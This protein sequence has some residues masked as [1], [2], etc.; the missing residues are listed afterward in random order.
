MKKMIL[1][2]MKIIMLLLSA[3]FSGI[4][5]CLS[6]AGLIYN[7]ESYG[8]EISFA[9]ALWIV[10]GVLMVSGAFTSLFR[11]SFLR[12]ISII[13]S[14]AGGCLCVGV[15]WKICE[16]ADRAGWHRG[17]LSEPVSEMYIARILPVLIPVIL[18]I[19]TAAINKREK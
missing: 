17:E 18:A 8:A 15:L 9:G 12:I 14:A 10:S 3:V 2:L 1:I 11:K 16:H 5:T 6:G 13:C 4:F 7:G 19:L